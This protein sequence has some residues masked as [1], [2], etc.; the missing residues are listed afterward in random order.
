MTRLHVKQNENEKQNQR[1]SPHL[2][3]RCSAEDALPGDSYGRNCR[4][5]AKKDHRARRRAFARELAARL[6]KSPEETTKRAE[7]HG[8]KE[9]SSGATQGADTD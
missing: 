2:C 6:T 3:S 8:Q 5:Q 1:V 7:E 9:D 4:R